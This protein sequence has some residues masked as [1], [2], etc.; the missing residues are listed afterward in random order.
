MKHKQ[1]KGI[2]SSKLYRKNGT[3]QMRKVIFTRKKD[4]VTIGR[5]Q[6]HNLFTC[7]M[8]AFSKLSREEFLE[9]RWT[10]TIEGMNEDDYIFERNSFSSCCMVDEFKLLL[11]RLCIFAC[12]LVG[13]FI[14]SPLIITKSAKARQVSKSKLDERSS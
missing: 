13:I 5:L 2:K 12:L 8:F 10:L 6:R 9:I 3:Y 14:I 1:F 4:S 7:S 11:K